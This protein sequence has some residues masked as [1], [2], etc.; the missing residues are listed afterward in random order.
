MIKKAKIIGTGS[1]LPERVLT[2]GDLEQ[3]VETSDEWIVTRTGI[4]E[5]RLARPDEYSSSMGAKAAQVALKDA[6]LSPDQIDFVLVATITPDYVFPSTACLIQQIL[7]MKNVGGVDI[8]AACSGYLYALSMA[9]A[10][11]ESGVYKNILIVVVDKLSSITDYKDRATCILFGDGAAACVVSGEGKGLSIEAIQLG[12][13]GDQAQL[14]LIPAGGCRQPASTESVATGQH[15][16][17]MAG[18]ELFKHAVRRMESASKECL[19]AA[20]ISE[21]EIAWVIPHQANLRIID[22]MAKRFEH[23]PANRV[24]K[25]LQKY[26]N[27]SASSLGIALDELLKAKMANSGERIL[28][29]AFGGGLTWGAAILHYE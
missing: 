26:G 23:L 16:I 2:N 15:Y 22:A 20:G 27:T 28:L 29:I 25:T 11:V 12:A 9:K 10:W 5:R 4:K 8:Q 7:G 1:Y 6:A 18:N 19:E 21:K 14:L 13:D 3:M 24:F 17:K